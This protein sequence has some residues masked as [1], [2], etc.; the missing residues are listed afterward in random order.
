MDAKDGFGLVDDLEGL[1]G[2]SGVRLRM[3]P[4]SLVFSRLSI[5]AIPLSKNHFD[6]T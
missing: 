3:L 1:R 6:V 5:S 4:A 2:I